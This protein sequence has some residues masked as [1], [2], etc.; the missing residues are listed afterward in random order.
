[1]P[2]GTVYFLKITVKIHTKNLVMD[3]LQKTQN[4]KHSEKKQTLQNFTV[5]SSF[6]PISPMTDNPHSNSQTQLTELNN[7]VSAYTRSYMGTWGMTECCYLPRLLGPRSGKMS[8]HN[9][10]FQFK[11]FDFHDQQKL[12]IAEPNKMKFNG[13]FLTFPNFCSGRPL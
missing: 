13:I 11:K 6:R 4:Y 2:L 5:P 8:R 9:E 1:M 10:R 7:N 12:E 3:C